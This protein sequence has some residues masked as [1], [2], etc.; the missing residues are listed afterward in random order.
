MELISTFIEGLFIIQPSIFK[1]ERGKFVKTYNSTFFEKNNLQTS[2][3]EEYHSE[4]KKNVIR[5]LHFQIPP[6]DHEKIVF[7]TKG[8]ILDV[9]VD[10]R[11]KSKTYG[12]LFSKNLS[13]NNG[14]MV[15]IPKGC[16]HGFLSLQD[17]TIVNYK[18]S[19]LYNS[20]ADDGILWSSIDFD[21]KVENPQLS[22]R[23][24]NFVQFKELNTPFKF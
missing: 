7:C 21:W 10:L 9:I 5:G 17:D 16:A 1:D 3:K 14:T 23:D 4:S 12:K 24:C 22:I 8:S 13:E 19:T 18:V 20:N 2:W 6:H 11:E 15:Y